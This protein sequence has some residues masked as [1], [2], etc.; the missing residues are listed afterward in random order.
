VTNPPGT[1]P[2]TILRVLSDGAA[3]KAVRQGA[4]RALLDGRAPSVSELAGTAGLDTDQIESAI[5]ELRDQGALE[6]DA[7]GRVIGAHGLRQRTT[8]HAI[9]TSD[10]TWHTWC[11]LDAVGIP[12]ALGLDMD[13][14]CAAANLFCSAEHVDEWRTQAGDPQGQ[15]LTLGDVADQGRQVWS[16]VRLCAACQEL[17]RVLIGTE[18]PLAVAAVEAIHTGDVDGLRRLLGENPE[19]ATAA[20]GTTG[21]DG[22]TRT[23]LHVATD[24]P[25]H[26]PNAGATVAVLVEAGADVNGR[27]S[28][29]LLLTGDAAGL[30]NPLQGEGISQAM[31]SGRAAAQAALADPARAARRYR[32][33]LANTYAPYHSTT[34][35]A[36]QALLPRPRVVSAVGRVLTAPALGSLLA[37]GWSIFWNDLLDGAQPTMP[38]AVAAVAAGIGRTAA[39]RG[40]MREWFTATL[41][42]GSDR[43]ASSGSPPHEGVSDTPIPD[44]AS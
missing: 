24:W 41:G 30:V 8:Q 12:V 13:D 28:G 42:P 16:D 2:E 21:D 36:H 26:F 6:V 18:E 19:L 22:M 37:P 17:R 1:P 40:R 4:F 14:F 15:L 31:S 35:P 29:P 39:A 38:R 7:S 32:A 34:A 43:E 11:A 5:D 9:I 3:V 10:R 44:R 27:F 20:L 23:L 25:G 33:Y